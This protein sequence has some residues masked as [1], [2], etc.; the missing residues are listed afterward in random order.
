M[1]SEDLSRAQ[2]ISCESALLEGQN[3][4]SKRYSFAIKWKIKARWEEAVKDLGGMRLIHCKFL[5]FLD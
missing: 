5:R 2:T 4:G 1:S 3:L